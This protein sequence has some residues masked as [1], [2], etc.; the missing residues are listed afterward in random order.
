MSRIKDYIDEM[1]EQGV[2]ILHPES[3]IDYEYE[4][5]RSINEMNQIFETSKKEKDENILKE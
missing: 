3:D 4:F 1:L 5:Q 2:D